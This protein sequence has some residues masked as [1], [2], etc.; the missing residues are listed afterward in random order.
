MFFVFFSDIYSSHPGLLHS[1]SSRH[2]DRSTA[3]KMSQDGKDKKVFAFPAGPS[4]PPLVFGS[5]NFGDFAF[6]TGPNP[7]RDR[8]HIAPTMRALLSHR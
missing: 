8:K 5:N 1:Q 4:A 7:E 2:I 6:T 3:S